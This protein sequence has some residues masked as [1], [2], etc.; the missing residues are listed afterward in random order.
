[1]VLDTAFIGKKKPSVFSKEY[2]LGFLEEIK[3]FDFINTP[4]SSLIDKIRIRVADDTREEIEDAAET[5]FAEAEAKWMAKYKESQDE[6]DSLKADIDSQNG[7]ISDLQKRSGELMKENELL[8]SSSG[9]L[10][11]LEAK[12]GAEAKEQ[13]QDDLP[14]GESPIAETSSVVEGY[15]PKKKGARQTKKSTGSTKQNNSSRSANK[16]KDKA[17]TEDADKGADQ[18]QSP[19]KEDVMKPSP[20]K[21]DGPSLFD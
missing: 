13:N 9:L 8:K 2:L 18:P 12:Y 16:A 6:I 21:G 7:I 3:P 5:K 10:R 19:A 14:I 1:M 4:L 17:P 11:E 15:T 20:N